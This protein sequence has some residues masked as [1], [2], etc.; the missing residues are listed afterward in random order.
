VRTL[1]AVEADT[2]SLANLGGDEHARVVLSLSIAATHR[3]TGKT[4]RIDQRV[5]VEVGTIKA[6]EGWLALS[7]EFDLPPGVVQARVVV[8]DEFLGRVGA[9]TVRFVVPRSGGFRV[10]TPV[11]TD[12]LSLPGEG[13]PARPVLVAHRH[14]AAG[15]LYC[16]F[17]VFGSRPG[18]DQGVLASFELRR[19]NGDSIRQGPATPIA[20]GPDGRLVRLLALSLEDLAPGDYELVLRVLDKSTGESRERVEP[21]RIEA[22]AS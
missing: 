21:M 4:Q 5:E 9:L 20:K 1:L 13:N 14:F 22:R 12:R 6:W 7:R 11:L 16:Q 3:D 18:A 15:P 8:K 10:S 17:Q 19:V 2:R